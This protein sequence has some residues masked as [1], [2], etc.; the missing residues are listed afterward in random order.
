ML[1]AML[2]KTGEHIADTAHKATRATAAMTEA[3]ED[4]I[5]MAKRAVKHTCDAA[6]EF[7]DDTTQ[8]IKRHPAETVVASF[9]I[10]VV[11]G[12]MMGWTARR[13]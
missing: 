9:A 8:R 3:F 10:G 5:G 2:E 7:M 11:L 6:E 13:K 12:M 1:D 4:S